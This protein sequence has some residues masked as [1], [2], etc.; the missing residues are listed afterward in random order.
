MI[1]RA[2]AELSTFAAACRHLLSRGGAL[3][4]MK[5]SLSHDEV[6]RLPPDVEARRIVALH[7]PFV[8]AERHLVC[9]GLRIT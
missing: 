1:S 5:G 6:G 4:A 9:M 3:L 8:D 2:F 7:V